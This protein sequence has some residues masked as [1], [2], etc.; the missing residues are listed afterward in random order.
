MYFD[1]LAAA[2][3]AQGFS[4][5]ILYEVRSE[6]PQVAFVGCGQGIAPVPATL[7][8]LAPKNVVIRPLGEALNVVTTALVWSTARVNPW[9]EEVVA[10]LGAAASP[11]RGRG[12]A[13][14]PG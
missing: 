5:R 6:V 3:R 13:V 1:S 2:C 12:D 4:P 8:K 14:I 7:K 10:T 9:V 11:R